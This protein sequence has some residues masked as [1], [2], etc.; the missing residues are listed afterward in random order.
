MPVLASSTYRAPWLL[1]NGHAQTLL[2]P[3]WRNV[4]APG[5]RRERL[6]LADG[7]FLDLDWAARSA[8]DDAAGRGRLA[9]ISY[10]ME[11]NAER[12]Y[13]AGMVR[14]LHGAGW[15]ALVWNYRSCGGEPNRKV[16]FYHG[17]LIGDLQAVVQHA[18]RGGYRELALI[19][20]SLGGNL[21]LNYLGR[22]SAE[23]PDAVRCAVAISAPVDV[24]DCARVM[25]RADNRLYVH[26][27]LKSFRERIRRKM[28][29]MP[30][31]ISDTPFA[32][33]RTL[34][35][36][37]ER[38]TAPH[39]G[40]QSVPDFYRF[41]SSRYWLHR[42]AVPT[43]IVNARNDPFMGP[44]C[45][46]VEEA[47]LNPRVHLEMPASGGH[48]GFLGARRQGMNWVEARALAFLAEGL[49]QP[50]DRLGGLWTALCV[51]RP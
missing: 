5:Y 28:R 29:A 27:F 30:G 15:D 44:D 11:G 41:V 22:G 37:D 46:P 8:V 49:A 25:R 13:V 35:D 24:E 51:E 18:L 10:G 40:F 16:H 43:L 32:Q 48:L 7:D 33:I 42:V 12:G 39:F 23:V 2:A 17:G 21:T 3:F 19:G 26:R 14:A 47:R 36:Y 20:F 45:F 31:K 1:R 38:Y 50:L 9:I 34:E 4:P 6:E